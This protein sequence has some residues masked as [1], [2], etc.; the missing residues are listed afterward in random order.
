MPPLFVLLEP[1]IW[2][3]DQPCLMYSFISTLNKELTSHYRVKVPGAV[4]LCCRVNPRFC[5]SPTF[6]VLC[7]LSFLFWKK[8]SCCQFVLSGQ[9]IILYLANGQE[10]AFTQTGLQICGFKKNKVLEWILFDR[11]NTLLR[12]NLLLIFPSLS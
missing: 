2:R 5:V 3:C 12:F 10:A 7:F 8:N 11:F 9:S 6:L 1:P 4:S